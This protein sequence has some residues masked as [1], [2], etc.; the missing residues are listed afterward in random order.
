MELVGSTILQIMREEVGCAVGGHIYFNVIFSLQVKTN[1]NMPLL[2][3]GELMKS[4][5]AHLSGNSNGRLAII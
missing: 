5:A 3:H 1:Q 2:Q 4:L